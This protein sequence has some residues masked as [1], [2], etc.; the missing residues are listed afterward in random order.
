MILLLYRRVFF[1]DEK[2]REQQ[3][4]IFN[5]ELDKNTAFYI[6]TLITDF[7]FLYFISL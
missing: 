4:N 6:Y 7:K 5:L 1:E 3:Q 2:I